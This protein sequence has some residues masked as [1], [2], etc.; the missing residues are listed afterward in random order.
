MNT[1]VVWCALIALLALGARAQVPDPTAL[2]EQ[3]GPEAARMMMGLQAVQEKYSR[4]EK[5]R[6]LERRQVSDAIAKEEIDRARRNAA[7]LQAR[8]VDPM[9]AAEVETRKRM[10]VLQEQW[11]AEDAQLDAQMQVEMQRAMQEAGLLVPSAAP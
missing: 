4:I 5:E 2:V 6:E 1:R 9:S 7:S 3:L 11:R 8:G 10:V